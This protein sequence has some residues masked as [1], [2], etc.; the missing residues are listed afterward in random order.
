VGTY[1][2]ATGVWA[3]GTVTTAAVQTLRI[4]AR[5]VSPATQVDTAAISHADEFD[6][7]PANNAA[8]VTI[9]PAGADLAITNTVT[10]AAPNV[11]DTITFMAIVS[12]NGPSTA[13]NVTVSDLLPAGLAFVAAQPSAGTYSS[14]TGVWTVGTVTTGVIQTLR[15]D[16]TVISPSTLVDTAAIAHADQFDP[17]TA[18]NAAT[19]VVS[20]ATGADLSIAG[21]VNSAQ[22][23]VGDTITFTFNLRD[24]GPTDATNVV[25]SAAVPA[26]LTLVS[27][28]TNQGSYAF[29]SGTWSVGTVTTGTPATLQLTAI[30]AS[31]DAATLTAAISH[32]DQ[33]DPDT[34]NNAATVVVSPATADLALSG[35][36]SNAQPNVGDTIALTF[37][38]SDDGP[39]GATNVDVHAA[40][41][42]GLT[43]ASATTTQGSYA[44]ASGTWSV[45]AVAT[46][47]PA[48][49]QLTAVVASSASAATT[50]TISHADQ[51]DPDTTNNAFTITVA[52]R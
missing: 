17:N 14:T 28:S 9:S 49:L 1:N 5:V 31:P 22:P 15:I 16:A 52:P 27:A 48:T 45:G 4:D 18:N 3:V 50:A 34:T 24:N 8:T 26:T 33:L 20:P 47:T 37:T 51:F 35:T 43:F 40:L 30:V 21:T 39:A 6:P 41:P 29:A 10:N 12:D 36:V 42:A 19:V 44:S 23:N 11:G 32:A 46:G 2:P 13:T 25:V 38:L 7:A